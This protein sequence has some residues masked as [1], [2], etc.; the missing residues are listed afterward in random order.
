MF[1]EVKE[2]AIRDGNAL[3]RSARADDAADIYACLRD[4]VCETPY[5][6]RSPD[7][8]DDA[9]EK[10]ERYIKSVEDS[11][12]SLKLLAIVG[13]RIA[14][15]ARLDLEKRR[16]I[17]HRGEIGIVAIRKEFWRHGI[18]RAMLAELLQAAREA[19][20]TQLELDVAATNAPALALYKSLGFVETG[21]RKHGIILDD[22]TEI[23]EIFMQMFFDEAC[24]C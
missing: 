7:E 9:P 10:Y 23:D 13:G 19:N 2:I 20:V 11:P 6:Y 1:R 15:F 14:G 8:C 3:L 5:M 24:R 21:R 4:C 22:G 16:K 12:Y 17:R 18:G